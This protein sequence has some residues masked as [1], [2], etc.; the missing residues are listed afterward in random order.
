[1][2]L[3]E[4][5]RCGYSTNQK[6][7]LRKHFKRKRLCKAKK[8]D[9]SISACYDKYFKDNN[10]LTQKKDSLNGDSNINSL[11]SHPKS[12]HLEPK[13]H[14][15]IEKKDKSHH[16]CNPY[17]N[18]LNVKLNNTNN[19][20]K[21]NEFYENSDIPTSSKKLLK[22]NHYHEI[23]KKLYKCDY[24]DAMY[25]YRQGKYRHQTS[26]EFRHKKIFKNLNSEILENSENS[27]NSEILE[28]IENSEL[29]A[30][31]DAKDE[32]IRNL[33]QQVELLLTKVGN[34]TTHH[35]TTNNTF[36]IVLNAF[37]KEKTD[38][39]TGNTI[40]KL[41][42]NG[43]MKSI[44]RLLQHIHFDPEHEENHN[45]K[46]T[47]KKESLAQVF[48][49]HSWTYV[50]KKETISSMTDKA[51]DLINEHYQQ[52]SNKYMDEFQ[53]KYEQDD[54]TLKKQIKKNTEI[55]VL[56]ESKEQ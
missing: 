10:N 41:I 1:M 38:Y 20:K 5:D 15:S 45:V 22:S 24:C 4:C 25:T 14:H 33:Q 11:K 17:H 19:D 53:D 36:N 26:C 2:V 21:V 18:N 51:Y 30:K 29:R 3:Y 50:D 40:K 37:G 48:N 42:K 27:E 56:N 31:L 43:P 32:V 49:G 9:I 13:S 54:K 12:H 39:I 52:G 28:N 44:P 34:T 55:M 23:N 16:Q 47:N 6:N 35:N 7:D 8:R 46:I